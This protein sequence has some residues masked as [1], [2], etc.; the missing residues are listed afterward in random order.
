[1]S[2][3][4]RFVRLTFQIPAGVTVRTLTIEEPRGL[5]GMPGFFDRLPIRLATESSISTRETKSDR[6]CKLELDIPEAELSAVVAELRAKLP[7]E[8][9]P[10]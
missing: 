2:A 9:K 1:M 10:K 6:V 4:E 3:P 5:A 8:E 7:T